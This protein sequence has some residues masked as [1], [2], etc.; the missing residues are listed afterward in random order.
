MTTFDKSLWKD[1]ARSRNKRCKVRLGEELIAIEGIEK[2]IEWCNKRNIKVEFTRTDSGSFD[3]N[4]NTIEVNAWTSPE[5]QLYL[6]FH[7]SGHYLVSKCGDRRVRFAGKR[8]DNKQSLVA[9]IDELAEEF[10]AWI[11]GRRLATRLRITIDDSK[12]EQYK[13]EALATYARH[14]SRASVMA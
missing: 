8:L 6:L 4:T 12:F 13:A 11:R 5:A 10:E 9:K 14:V 2:I 1:R 3:P 7:E